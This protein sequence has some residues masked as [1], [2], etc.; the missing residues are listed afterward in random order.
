MIVFN[1][2]TKKNGLDVTAWQDFG[3]DPVLVL[4]LSPRGKEEK[5]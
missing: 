2:Y 5:N 1:S 4:E 3:W